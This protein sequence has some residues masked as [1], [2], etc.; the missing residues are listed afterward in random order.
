MPLAGPL[1]VHLVIL[2]FFETFVRFHREIED[3]GRAA[4]PAVPDAD[5]E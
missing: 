3:K 4:V 2:S 5:V 1:F